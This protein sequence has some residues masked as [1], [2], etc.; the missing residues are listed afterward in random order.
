MGI[1]DFQVTS[2]EPLTELHVKGT[3]RQTAST[4]A[5]LV[6]N[7]SGDIVSASVLADIP[8]VPVGQAGADPYNP[9]NPGNWQGPPPNTIEEAIQRIATQLALM[10]GPIP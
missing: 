8:Y 4:N 9:A 2:D 6:S 1:G 7:G 5:V 10:A 3:I